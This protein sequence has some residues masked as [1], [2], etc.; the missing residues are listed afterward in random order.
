MAVGGGGGR[1]RVFFGDVAVLMGIMVST[2]QEQEAGGFEPARMRKPCEEAARGRAS[3]LPRALAPPSLSKAGKGC[4]GHRDPQET[5]TNAFRGSAQLAGRPGSNS[6]QAPVATQSA[7][8]TLTCKASPWP[9]AGWYR[10]PCLTD[11]ETEASGT[12][13]C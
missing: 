12:H 9:R 2:C 6:G 5:N 7:S 3:V 4:E 11:G 10:H 8:P 13:C 1:G